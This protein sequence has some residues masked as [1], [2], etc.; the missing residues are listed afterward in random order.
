VPY[1]V[2]DNELVPSPAVLTPWIDRAQVVTERLDGQQLRNGLNFPGLS[3]WAA[4][5][6]RAGHKASENGRVHLDG[7]VSKTLNAMRLAFLS[8]EST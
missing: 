5:R 1:L 8:G 6:H 3:R 2:V 7:G 4:R